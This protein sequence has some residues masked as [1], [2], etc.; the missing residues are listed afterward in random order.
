MTTPRTL[1]TTT[2]VKS[3]ISAEVSTTWCHTWARSPSTTYFG[4]SFW[5]PSNSPT[6]ASFAPRTTRS[7]TTWTTTRILRLRTSKPSVLA[8]FGV[9]LYG[10]KER[11]PDPPHRADTPRATPRTSPVKTEQYNKYKRPGGHEHVVFVCDTLEQHGEK[12]ENKSEK[13]LRRADL[14]GADW[15]EP[16]SVSALF[17]GRQKTLPQLGPHPATLTMT[18]ILTMTLLPPMNRMIA[19]EYHSCLWGS[20]RVI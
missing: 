10:T 11:H 13:V 16:A 8:N 5:L 14:A 15:N 7:S 4:P 20:Y 18:M 2:S 1:S 12:P 3:A 6:T 17:H 19:P 9:P